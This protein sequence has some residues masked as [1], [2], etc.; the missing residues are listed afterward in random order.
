MQL[1]AGMSEAILRQAR[2][3]QAELD[4]EELR[5][6]GLS[7]VMQVPSSP[8][9]SVSATAQLALERRRGS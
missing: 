3:Q 9:N 6:R 1:D 2:E 8:H 7:G 5:A 4:T